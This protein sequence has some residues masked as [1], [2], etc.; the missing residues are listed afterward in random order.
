MNPDEKKAAIERLRAKMD[1]ALAYRHGAGERLEVRD[2]KAAPCVRQDAP[3]T[4]A[5]EG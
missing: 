4:V 1:A 5:R 3:R 2:V